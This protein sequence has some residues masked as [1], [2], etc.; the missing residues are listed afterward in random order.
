[1][2]IKTLLTTT[3]L[4][5]GLAMTAQ[6]Q[7]ISQAYEVVLSDFR[8]PATANGGAA[9]KQCAEC[10]RQVIRVT[11]GT[12]YAINGKTVRLEDFRKAV[13]LANDRDEKWVTVLHH[14][15]SDTIE[16]IDVLL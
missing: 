3:L 13:L 1:M 7:V 14:L 9:F 15:E 10:D 12:R 2:K 8:A 11:A 5:L 4:C 16:S 6:A